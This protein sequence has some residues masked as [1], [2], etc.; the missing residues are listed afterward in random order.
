MAY[1][2]NASFELD[3]DDI[4]LDSSER[5]TLIENYLEDMT[6][7]VMVDYLT[8]NYS[9]VER[10]KF[11]DSLMADDD[12]FRAEVVKAYAREALDDKDNGYFLATYL[13]RAY[14]GHDVSDL[15]FISALIHRLVRP[16]PTIKEAEAA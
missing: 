9:L 12:D 16:A 8:R 6:P 2:N 14:P 5:Q 1:V 4:E 10:G 7:D 11:I 13:D 15:A 3:L